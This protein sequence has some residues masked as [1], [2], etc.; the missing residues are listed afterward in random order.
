MTE[1]LDEI[2]LAIVGCSCVAEFGQN[3]RVNV[4]VKWLGLCDIN[5]DLGKQLAEDTNADFYTNDF[6][7][8][9]KRPEVNAVMIIADENKH[10]G[11]YAPVGRTGS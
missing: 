3:L 5:D 6:N 1:T 10:T 11:T 8:L 9:I 4:G 7:E 2:G